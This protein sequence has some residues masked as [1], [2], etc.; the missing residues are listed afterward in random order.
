[1]MI[2]SVWLVIGHLRVK[3]RKYA[4]NSKYLDT[5]S[6]NLGLGTT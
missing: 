2:Y 5:I 6:N 3:R 4:I 1:M